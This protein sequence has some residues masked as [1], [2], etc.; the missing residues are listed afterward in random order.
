M[1]VLLLAAVLSLT[2]PSGPGAAEPHLTATKS[3]ALVMSWLE[4]AGGKSHALRFA[5]YRDGKWGAARTIAT[6]DDF[7]VNWAD[8]PS[9]VEDAQGTLFAHWLQKSGSGTY[10]YDV[11]VAASR[12]GGTTWKSKVLNTDG[13]EAEHGFVSLVPL[14]RSGVGALWLDGRGM[15]E[16]HGGEHAG[17]MEL[18][19]ADLDAALYARNESVLDARVCEC[20][21]TAMTMTA[22]GPLVAYRDRAQDETRDIG[23]ARRVK[24][25]WS[26][27]KVMVSDGW[28]IPGCPVNGPQLASRGNLVAAAWFTAPDNKAQ[29]KVAF[30]RDGGASFGAPVRADGGTNAIGRVDVL[31]LADD[32]ALV[33]WIEGEAIMLRRVRA[34]GTMDATVKLATTTSARAAGFPRGVAIGKNAYFA[35][36]DATAK[37]I[38]L[39]A[40]PVP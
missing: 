1:T 23:F 4:P 32:S 24:G 6:R 18:R 28:K 38:R 29:V 39:A 30:S 9:I 8:F 11:H 3:G 2:S 17:S 26:Q 14:S 31:L 12:D 21:T 19:Y 16:G 36:T 40:V 34:N 5:S 25:K 33:S 15:T 7:F 27:P 35:W 37:Q 22:N 10:A 13:K 20:C